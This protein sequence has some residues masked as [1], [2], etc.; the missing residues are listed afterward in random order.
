MSEEQKH[1]IYR[2]RT[3]VYAIGKGSIKNATEV[4][5]FCGGGNHPAEYQEA[6]DFLTEERVL[7]KTAEGWEANPEHPGI[8]LYAR[9]LFKERFLEVAQGKIPKNKNSRAFKK[10]AERLGRK[11][12]KKDK[13]LFSEM[14]AALASGENVSK[15]L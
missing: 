15:Y 13:Q 5:R 3:I 6:I 11:W 4:N 2:E 7:L 9:P 12:R 10:E 14:Q 1:N 8:K